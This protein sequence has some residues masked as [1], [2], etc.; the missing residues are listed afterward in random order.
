VNP[1]IRG[2]PLAAA[3][4]VL[5]AGAGSLLVGAGRVT[6]GTILAGTRTKTTPL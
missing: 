2:V 4:G 6:H 5:A 3:G 1:G